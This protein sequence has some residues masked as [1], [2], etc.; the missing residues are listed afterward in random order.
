MLSDSR[1]RSILTK[2][3]GDI[4]LRKLIE[5]KK[6]LI[7]KV[8][9]G[10]LDQ[11]ANLLG[12]LIVTGVKQAALSLANEA[13]AKQPPVALYLDEFDNFI[14]KKQ[15]KQLHRKPTNSRSASSAASRHCNTCRRTSVTN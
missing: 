12:S 10:Q 1:I 6:V 5:E 2:P 4:K 13:A 8:A 14:E 11:N 15:L 3:V 9:K 7:V